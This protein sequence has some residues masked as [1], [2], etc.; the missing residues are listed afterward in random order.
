MSLLWKVAST[1]EVPDSVEHYMSGGIGHQE[2][3]ESRSVVGM[4]P[5]S[6]L[7]R[8]REHDG[9]Q[10]AHYEDRDH[11]IISDIH[12]DIKSGK[13]IHTPLMMEYDHKKGWG[14]LG[15]G[16]HR[17]AAGEKAG[18]T[19]LPVRVVGR[20]SAYERP[21]KGIG[22]PLHLGTEWKGGMGERYI[23]PDIHPHH[24]DELQP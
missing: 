8:Y 19:H 1:P 11:R 10:N 24:F 15:E 9:N 17:L 12:D 23:P 18:L 16:N 5:V 22:A 20:S 4:V 14:W 21:E 13:G 2:G 7:K 6:T 3:D